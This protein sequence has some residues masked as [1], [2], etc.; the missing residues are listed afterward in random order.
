MPS[1]A[2]TKATNLFREQFGGEPDVLVRSP[3]RVNLIGDHTDYNDGFVLPMA[4]DRALWIAARRR[5][6]RTVHVTTEDAPEAVLDLDHLEHRRGEWT[7]YVIGV[8]WS[9]AA[10][11]HHTPG[12]EG[13]LASD[14]PIGAGLSSS[15][16]LELAV[17]RVFAVLSGSSW[18]A[19]AVA[20][21]A[22]RAENEW[23]GMAC[24][25]MDQLVVATAE[26]G[27]ALL[28]D[29]RSLVRTPV[30][31][32]GGVSVLIVDSGT[33]RSLVE[34]AYN[35]RRAACERAAAVLGVVALRDVDLGAVERAPLDAVTMRRARHV[36]EENRRVL[37]F[38]GHLRRGDVIAAGGLM[39]ASHASLRDD[40]EVSTPALD[41]L[42]TA[43]VAS[44]GCFGARLTGAGFGGCLVALAASDAA[45]SVATGILAHAARLG[46]HDASAFT[47]LPAGGVE[48]V[49]RRG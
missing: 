4:I 40:F 20:Q 44:D 49:E 48:V 28:I 35:D 27:A 38:A 36:V 41:A 34:S 33:R 45:T 10:G 11:G 3:G 19:A 47:S 37:D 30:P 22:Q 16:A 12:W 7:E 32:P 29:C 9:L 8:A 23:V 26:E 14:I 31:M 43:L 15:A 21:L 25:I 2:A 17:S 24:G 1:H 39:T 13:A 42:A 18:E 6:D 5:A 46:L